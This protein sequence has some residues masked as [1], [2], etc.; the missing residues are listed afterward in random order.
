VKLVFFG[1]SEFACPVLHAI[2]DCYGIDLVVTQPDR[3]AGRHAQ[4]YPSPVKTVALARN[5][6]LIQ[7]KNINDAESVQVLLDLSADVIVV[8]SYGQLLKPVVFDI[9]RL[10]TINIHAS[11]LPAYRG[12]APVNWAIMRGET[13]TGIST[14]FIEK[15][16]DTGDVLMMEALDIGVEETAAELEERLAALGSAVILRTVAGLLEGSLHASKQPVEGISLAPCLTREDGHIDW[17]QPALRIHNLVRGTLPWPGAWTHVGSQ[18]VKIHRTQLTGL[19]S[20]VL[21]PGEIGPAESQR[22]LVG[23][24][25][26]LL[27][28]IEL[29]REGKSRTCGSD[30]L[31]GVHLPATFA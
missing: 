27:E 12:A 25:D 1:S 6:P 26:R 16:L 5:L 18:R 14:F 4:L 23:T 13:A 31:H 20:G 29:Q 11:L 19:A 7:P 22:L 10:G 28:I 21:H 3:Q 24:Q 9:P 17:H 8:A 30:F 15:G 2:D